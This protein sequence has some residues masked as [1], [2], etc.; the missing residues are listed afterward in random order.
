MV[1][2][3][4]V[5][6]N[7]IT[8]SS[9]PGLNPTPIAA[10]TC[11]FLYSHAMGSD[12]YSCPCLYELHGTYLVIADHHCD[13]GDRPSYCCTAYSSRGFYLHLARAPSELDDLSESVMVLDRFMSFTSSSSLALILHKAAGRKHAVD[14][15]LFPGQ[16]LRHCKWPFFALKSLDWWKIF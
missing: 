5:V 9:G 15:R 13:E 8:Q 14:G 1:S 7:N 10:V 6:Q 16:F 3:I 2:L 4:L 12:V 11:A